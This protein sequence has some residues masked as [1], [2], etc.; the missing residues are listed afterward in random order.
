MVENLAVRKKIKN[1][2]GDGEKNQKFGAFQ[3]FSETLEG[4][5]PLKRSSDRR[6][7]LRK[8]VSDDPRQFNFRRKKKSAT[9]FRPR[10]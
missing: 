6:E 8:R 4:R 3:F 2:V 1:P 10:V 9:F 7:T 5:L